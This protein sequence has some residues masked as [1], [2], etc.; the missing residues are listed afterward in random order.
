VSQ[1]KRGKNGRNGH[2][3]KSTRPKRA[4]LEHGEGLLDEIPI[5]QGLLLKRN[6]RGNIVFFSVGERHTR[7]LGHKVTELSE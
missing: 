7:H 3:K 4:A 6:R 5:H 2:V 1:R